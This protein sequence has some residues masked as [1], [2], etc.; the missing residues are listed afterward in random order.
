MGAAGAL[1]P[2]RTSG[3]DRFGTLVGTPSVTPVASLSKW[4]EPFNEREPLRRW[5]GREATIRE[6]LSR[7]DVYASSSRLRIAAFNRDGAILTE[8]V[9]ARPI[10]IVE[11]KTGGLDRQKPRITHASTMT[12]KRPMTVR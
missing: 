8:P 5:F 7:H 10:A 11:M 1:G 2:R 6:L 12:A 4:S 9:A 3:L